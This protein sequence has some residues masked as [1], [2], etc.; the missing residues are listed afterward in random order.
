MVP[1]CEGSTQ[2]RAGLLAGG[3]GRG[4]PIVILSTPVLAASSPIWIRFLTP[5]MPGIHEWR[6][7]RRA[8]SIFSIATA[9]RY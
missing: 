9:G 1:G 6:P 7:T 4:A 5:G 8:T 3:S 2:I